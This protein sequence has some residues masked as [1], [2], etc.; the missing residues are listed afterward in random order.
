MNIF[1]LGSRVLVAEEK[2]E[3][4]TS[5]GIIIDGNAGDSRVFQVV[6]KGPDVWRGIEVG[7][8]VFIDSS[9]GQIVSSDGKQRILLP[10]DGITAII[11][12]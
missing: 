8:R 4:T 9:K 10:V 12:D 11:T 6:A 3:K 1:P 7:Q 5:F 2:V